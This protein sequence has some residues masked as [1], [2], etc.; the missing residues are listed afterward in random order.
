VAAAAVFFGT[1]SLIRGVKRAGAS[2]LTFVDG[3]QAALGTMILVWMVYYINREEQW[4]LWFQTVLLLLMW[5]PRF[6]IVDSRILR[7]FSRYGAI[8]Y[9]LAGSLLGGLLVSSM[10]LSLQL[11]RRQVVEFQGAWSRSEGFAGMYAIRDEGL[12]SM[13]SA[14]LDYLESIERK[15][16]YLL[17]SHLPTQVRLMGFNKGFPWYEPFAE[18]T[19][20]QDLDEIV[21]WIDRHGPPFLMLEN[22]HPKAY[23]E[24]VHRARHLHGIGRQLKRYSFHTEESGWLI[25]VRSPNG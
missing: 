11:W 2:A 7:G 24:V 21:T 12:A 3:Y 16:R 25:L 15:E 14:R 5:A 17:L 23:S 9:C 22:L 18:V 10:S 20:N 19:T 8:H 13:V 1:Y 4:N 6:R